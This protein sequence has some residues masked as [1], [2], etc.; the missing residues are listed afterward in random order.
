MAEKKQSYFTPRW[1][2]RLFM[3]RLSFGD[4]FYAGMFGSGLIFVPVGFVIAAIVVVP[5]PEV[6][7]ALTLW[8]TVFYAAY[9][10]ALFPAVLLTGL[11]SAQSGGWRWAGIGVALAATVLLW[12]AAYRFAL[13]L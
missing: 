8:M 10:S 7:P 5:A 4:T 11:K 3:A 2:A 12:W 1:F 9:F 6:M 13:A